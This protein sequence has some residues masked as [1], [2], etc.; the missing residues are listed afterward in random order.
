MTSK[1]SSGRVVNYGKFVNQNPN[2]GTFWEGLEMESVG[3]FYAPIAIWY[4]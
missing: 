2:L 3:I 4:I 1:T